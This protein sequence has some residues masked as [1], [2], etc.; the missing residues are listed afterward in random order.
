MQVDHAR[1]I[2]HDHL[3]G[4]RVPGVV[5]KT[6]VRPHAKKTMNGFSLQVFQRKIESP[7]GPAA[8]LSH[9]LQPRDAAVHAFAHARLGSAGRSAKYDA[10]R[11]DLRSK[12]PYYRSQDLN[13]HAGFSSPASD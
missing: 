10:V 8:A 3:M 4:Q 11:L 7:L 2:D 12:E 9:F 6:S 13:D 1:L 5:F